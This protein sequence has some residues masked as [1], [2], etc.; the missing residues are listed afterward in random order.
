MVGLKFY[1]S[2]PETSEALIRCER[3]QSGSP[4]EMTRELLAW[5]ISDEGLRRRLLP[6]LPP[7][8]RRALTL[9]ALPEP[10]TSSVVSGVS[11]SA[12]FQQLPL[13][14]RRDILIEAFGNRTLHL[15]VCFDHPPVPLR[16]RILR[17]SR[18]YHAALSRFYP[19]NLQDFSKPKLWHWRSSTC[20]RAAPGLVETVKPEESPYE[21]WVRLL[22]WR[23]AQ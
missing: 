22:A 8:R 13:H 9:P 15:T 7:R 23:M 1:Q 14:L 10:L 3:E 20:H 18:K 5:Y 11:N 19:S 12:F 4:G 21:S 16:E 2:P 17:P 6:V